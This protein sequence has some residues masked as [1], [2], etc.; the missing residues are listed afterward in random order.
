MAAIKRLIPSQVQVCIQ[1]ALKWLLAQ[2]NYLTKVWHKQTCSRP[3][4]TGGI[5]YNLMF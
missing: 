4:F 5:F 1:T 2:E 3:L